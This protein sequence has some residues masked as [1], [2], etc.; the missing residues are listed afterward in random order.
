MVTESIH[1]AQ[2]YNRWLR[3]SWFGLT[4]GVGLAG[5]GLFILNLNSSV[6]VSWGVPGGARNHLNNIFDAFQ[7]ALLSPLTMSI[8]GTLIL[9]R[10]PRHRIGALLVV[11]GFVTALGQLAQEWAVYTHFTQPVARFSGE[12][13]AW[14][15]NWI[16]LIIFGVLLLIAGLF[17]DGHFASTGWRWA[18]GLSLL[19]FALPLLVAAMFERRMSSVFQ[20]NN[21]WP[22]TLAAEW[23]AGLFNFGFI[24][25]PI[26]AL[27]VFASAIVRFRRSHTQARQQMKWL[28]VGVAFMALFT[29]VGLSLNFGLGNPLGAN[30]VN[31]AML[32]P[33]AGVGMALIRHRLYDVDILIR[34][35]LQYS[36]L[37]GVLG[38]TYFGLVIVLQN[39]T[40]AVGG[41]RSEFVTVLSTLAIAAL[42]FPLRNRVQEFIDK[43]FFR[44]KY[45]AQKVLAEFAATC[46][47]ETDLDKLV[48][49]LTDVIDETLQPEKVSVWFRRSD[50]HTK[51][52]R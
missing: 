30:L 49:R 32:G 2:F 5:F 46:R 35:T 48:T 44:R 17:P 6:P 1:P 22:L 39:L 7:Q 31:A 13:A 34:R 11:L 21:P 52:R 10:H 14:A 16:W 36:L 37:S 18:I 23:Y 27:L 29:V 15:T 51:A 43:R 50:T 24:F 8:F 41:Q 3:W 38:L 25:L 12:W 20:I 28:L 9:R 33:V 40:S 19:L 4:L 47:D 42:F 45:D 26:T